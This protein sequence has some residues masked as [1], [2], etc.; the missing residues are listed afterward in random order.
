MASKVKEGVKRRPVLDSPQHNSTR[1]SKILRCPVRGSSNSQPPRVVP[2]W[3]LER[4]LTFKFNLGSLSSALSM[5]VATPVLGST[6]PTSRSPLGGS[7]CIFMPSLFLL[8]LH[9]PSLASLVTS[10]SVS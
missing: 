7:S 9:H 10:V 6:F 1:L 3:G 4:V 8:M 5:M 2:K